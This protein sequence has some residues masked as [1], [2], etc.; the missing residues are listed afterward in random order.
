MLMPAARRPRRDEL[1]TQLSIKPLAP[2]AHP[3]SQ[4]YGSL[5]AA[6]GVGSWQYNFKVKRLIWSKGTYHLLGVP[7]G[8]PPSYDLF[9]R[10][11][12]P[13]DRLAIDNLDSYL[14]EVRSLDREFRIVDAN[15]TVRWIAHKAEV[16]VDEDGEQILA[17]GI[18]IDITARM[19]AARERDAAEK[20]LRAIRD[21]MATVTWTM[22]PN[23][24][25]PVSQGWMDLTGQGAKESSGL[26]WLDAVYEAD[27]EATKDAWL[28]AFTSKTRYAAKYRLRCH[29]GELRWFLAQAVP[30][31]D[32]SGNIEQWVGGLILI[33]E[34]EKRQKPTA[35]LGDVAGF[36]GAV[37]T[38]ARALLGW[39]LN[40]MAKRSGVSIST[41]RR[42][43]ESTAITAKK[44]IL[45]KLIGVLHE[46]GIEFRQED[47]DGWYVRR[48]KP[49]YYA[50]AAASG[51]KFSGAKTLII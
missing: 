7:E 1:N 21:T 48:K 5:E 12:H 42:I 36:S 26:G 50:A 6:A 38:A 44:P 29:D 11:T 46:A 41:I 31:F 13:D 49:P 9:A 51:T 35:D 43:E 23:G 16:I 37:M 30:I 25:K 24:D 40:D 2:E 4:L 15:G 20:R 27:R 3:L 34:V 14:R 17:V 18:L 10:F 22:A 33:D 8:T 28:K 45:T 19:N 39:S 47:A 32:A